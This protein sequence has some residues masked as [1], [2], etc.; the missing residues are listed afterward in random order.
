M[1]ATI[2]LAAGGTG[3]H[4]FPAEA[5]A[6][7]LGARGYGVALATD[8][9]A[10]AYGRDFPADETHIIRS[11]S[12]RGGS[13]IAK[14]EAAF[15]IGGGT[16]AARAILHR[17]RPAAVVGFGG[18][19]IV[20]PMLAAFLARVPTVLHEQNAVMGKAN[21]FLARRVT[22]IATSFAETRGL[23]DAGKAVHTGNPV[24]GR[25]IAAARAPFERPEPYG[26]LRVL[27]FGGSQGAKAFADLVPPAIQRLERALRARL[28]IVQQAR[29]EDQ[30][31]VIGAYASADVAAEIAT[32]FPD[33]PA[34]IAAAHLVIC[35]SGASSVAELSVIG[36]PAVLVPLPHALDDDQKYNAL[37][38]ERAGG[39][40]LAEQAGLTPDGLATLIAALAADPG[41][42]AAMAAAARTTGRPDAVTRL[43]DVVEAVARRQLV[44]EGAA[45]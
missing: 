7:E 43:A 45:P 42:L 44:T 24:R 25:V 28:S 6:S 8:H 40:I 11:A 38:L 27:V 39:A 18:Y 13:V 22:R 29:P 16:M 17:M 35:R 4:L 34:R 3:G 9:R 12:P 33:L 30:V 21:R 32:F 37:T 19:P 2:L 1:G 41:R 20:P 26:T 10:G 14:A 15:A 36:R 5:L 31:R 23:A